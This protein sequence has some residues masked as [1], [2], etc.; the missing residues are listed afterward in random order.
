VYSRMD[1]HR[2]VA[3]HRYKMSSGYTS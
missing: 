2:S 1:Q 3:N